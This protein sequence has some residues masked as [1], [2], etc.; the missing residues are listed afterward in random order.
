MTAIA[1]PEPNETTKSESAPRVRNGLVYLLAA[2]GIGAA[3]GLFL[4]PRPRGRL[5]DE[6]AEMT[7]ENSTEPLQVPEPLQQRSAAGSSK[8]CA[9]FPGYKPAQAASRSE[10]V[11]EFASKQPNPRGSTIAGRIS[12]RNGPGGRRSASIV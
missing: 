11:L 3:M 1:D 8:E 9:A 12:R 4:A 7:L 10:N 6:V 5:R 2:S